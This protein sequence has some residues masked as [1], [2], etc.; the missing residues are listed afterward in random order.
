[1]AIRR[2]FYGSRLLPI[3]SLSFE[4]TWKSA[5]ESFLPPEPDFRGEN[6]R[7]FWV[8][9]M[10]QPTANLSASG[11]VMRKTRQAL[12]DLRFIPAEP[13][14]DNSSPCLLEHRLVFGIH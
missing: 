5:D 1:M 2:H 3:F 12:A 4:R 13:E 8:Y 9:Q 11:E 6:G 7:K 14:L 10:D